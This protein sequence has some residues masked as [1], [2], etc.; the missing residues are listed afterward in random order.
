MTPWIASSFRS[1]QLTGGRR[2]VV[3][4][5]QRYLLACRFGAYGKRRQ[6]RAHRAG[7]PHWLV[8]GLSTLVSEQITS[9][10][11]PRVIATYMCL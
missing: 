4:A 9:V 7:K 5:E 11:L 3:V 8:Y 6:R 1:S 10:R 2:I